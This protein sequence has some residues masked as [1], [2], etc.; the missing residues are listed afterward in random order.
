MQVR[1]GS[2][3]NGVLTFEQLYKTFG[4]SWRISQ[5]ESLFEYGPGETTAT[6]TLTNFPDEYASTGQLSA[7]VRAQAEAICRSAGLVGSLL[8]SCILDIGSTGDVG[9]VN[10]VPGQG[11]IPKVLGV[12]SP[13]VTNGNGPL[14]MLGDDLLFL[15]GSYSGQSILRL[16]P[17]RQE[18]LVASIPTKIRDMTVSEGSIF[19]SDET[20]IYKVSLSGEASVINNSNQG[21]YIIALLPHRDGLILMER[22]PAADCG[23]YVRAGLTTTTNYDPSNFR[24]TPSE[25]AATQFWK[26]SP[27]GEKTFIVG[28]DYYCFANAFL[29]DNQIYMTEG[30]PEGFRPSGSIH[31]LTLDP[32][33]LTP[34]SLTSTALTNG[35]QLHKTIPY[36]D[37]Y[38][39]IGR[40]RDRGSF[41]Y[42]ILKIEPDQNVTELI[43]SLPYYFT[44]LLLKGNDLIIG[45]GPVYTSL[46]GRN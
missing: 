42:S 46:W 40:V 1:N 22:T 29:K 41:I 17:Q 44:G 12:L 36:E 34:I 14:A 37:S 27:R 45:W 30:E 6:Y 39:A 11:S 25:R 28:I 15:R 3:L 10:A 5:A 21:N 33:A 18:T 20:K 19:V 43:S 8:N 35:F 4:N 9:L 2:V 38:L 31:K 16:N 26:V 7:T 13:L 32:S 24:L 23:S